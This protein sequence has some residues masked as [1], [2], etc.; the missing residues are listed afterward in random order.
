MRGKEN[1]QPSMFSYINLEDRIKPDH[2]LVPIRN[3]VN[4][5]LTDMSKHFDT[6]YS[7]FGRPSIPPEYLL[8]GSILQILFSIRSERLLME[9][10]DYNLL[11]R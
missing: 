5:I 11:Y 1:L 7:I 2:P 10:I 4:T 6:L 8:K 3:L 9:N